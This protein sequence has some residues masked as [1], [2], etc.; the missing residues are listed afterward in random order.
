MA[1]LA[2]F[3]KKI[4]TQKFTLHTVSSD[5]KRATEN[6]MDANQT[7]TAKTVEVFD[8]RL[9]HVECFRALKIL[10]RSLVAPFAVEVFLDPHVNFDDR[11]SLYD[12]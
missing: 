2:I 3:S 8:A 1:I 10:Q 6:H 7:S 9:S 12:Q 4:A 11:L 5:S